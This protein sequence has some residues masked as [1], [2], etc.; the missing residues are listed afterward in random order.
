MLRKKKKSP[1]VDLELL[2]ASTAAAEP[3]P[4]PKFTYTLQPN[5]ASVTSTVSCVLTLRN[6]SS[7][8]PVTVSAGDII[9]V[10]GWAQITDTPTAISAI[11]PPGSDWNASFA[12]TSLGTVLQLFATDDIEVAPGEH[13]SFT[14]D[15]IAIDDTVGNVTLPVTELIGGTQTTA[16]PLAFAKLGS[17]LQ[18]F[19]WSDKD[20]VGAGESTNINWT[21]VQGT[22]VTVHPPGDSDPFPRS[23]PP[24]PFTGHTARTPNQGVPQTTFTVTVFQGSQQIPFLVVVNLAAP[25]ITRFG[26]KNRPPIAINE[27]VDLSWSVAYSPQVTLQPTSG[28]PLVAP[29]GVRTVKPRNFLPDNASSVPFFLTASGFGDPVKDTVTVTFQPMRIAWF[30]YPSFDQKNAYTSSAPNSQRTAVNQLGQSHFVLNAVGPGGPLTQE[31]GGTGLE[32]QVL[33]AEPGPAG[34]PTTLKYLVQAATS[35]VLQPGNVP[36]TFGADGRGATT[37]SPSATTTYTLV[38]TGLTTR[39]VSS[40]IIVFVPESRQK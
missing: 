19:A 27:E 23:G 7:E 12:A 14:L 30:R 35:L 17:T 36:L 8:F 5:S 18:I 25:R 21:I 1:V 3:A 37:V 33:V 38:A 29:E 9:V 15:N 4:I 24:G 16:P 6:P 34:Q 32:I 26:P 28:S 13:V 20:T 39:T 40:E 31:L 10:A 2:L 22:F 11:P